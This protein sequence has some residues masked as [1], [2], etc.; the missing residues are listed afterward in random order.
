MLAHLAQHRAR[1]HLVPDDCL[2]ELK[3]DAA[4][5]DADITTEAASRRRE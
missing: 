1:G 3:A 5:N 4:E 2:A